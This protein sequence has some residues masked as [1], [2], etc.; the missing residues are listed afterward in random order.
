MPM[1]S[2]AQ[3][4][5]PPRKNP[6]WLI[7]AILGVAGLVVGGCCVGAWIVMLVAFNPTPEQWDQRVKEQAAQR[8]QVE[9]QQATSDQYRA[10]AFLEYW[11]L[12]LEMKNLD[13]P[14]RLTTEAFQVR[15]S[16]EQFEKFI[17]A[18]PYLKERDH[19]WSHGVDGKPGDQFSFMLHSKKASMLFI[20]SNLWVERKAGEWRLDRLEDG[21]AR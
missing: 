18:R 4:E 15:M 8:W 20:N 19:N 17:Q 16:R 21:P 6:A 7:L 12:L 9:E 10:R 1:N 14:Y 5:T 11:L 13:E 2:N 3:D